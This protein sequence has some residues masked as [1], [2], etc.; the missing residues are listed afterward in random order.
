MH[1]AGELMGANTQDQPSA[2]SA[3]GLLDELSGLSGPSAGGFTQTNGVSDG[4]QANAANGATDMFGGLS[5]GG[6][7]PFPL[8]A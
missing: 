7:L 6:R 1:I 2:S 4:R 3:G 8:H 5:L